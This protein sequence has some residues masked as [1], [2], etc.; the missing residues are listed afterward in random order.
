MNILLIN[1]EYPPIGGG[2]GNATMF[3][4][5]ALVQL[6]HRATVLTSAF[7]E[8]ANVREEAGVAIHRLKVRRLEAN[9]AT[10][11]E[12]LS[13]VR[14]ALHAAPAVAA[15]SGTQ[16]VIVFFTLPCG[17]VAL[18]LHRRLGLPYV[19]SLRGGDVPGLVPEIRW[20]HAVLKPLRR[21]VLR[22][23]RAIVANDAGLAGLSSRAD[24]FPVRI[25]PNGVDSDFYRPP[26]SPKIKTGPTEILFVGRLHRQKN[27][28]FFLEQLA[29]LHAAEPGG[30][31]LS[32]VGDGEERPAL[33]QGVKRL[34]L[35]GITSWLGWQ[36]DKS[37]LLE[38]YQRADVVVNPS[39]YEG[40]PNVVLEAMACG[41][42]VVA[43]DVPGNN[44]LVRP[45]QTGFLFTLN[46]GPGLM[47]ALR[48]LRADP[49]LARTLGEN[50]RQRVQTEFSWRKVAQCYLELFQPDHD[51]KTAAL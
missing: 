46:D 35:G 49:V 24:P 45:G 41:L 18:S 9:R 11:R 50:A 22:S 40:M 19:V 28:P 16:A 25:I 42:P 20:Q 26:S 3:L 27:L 14:A 17:P 7:Q 39:H 48:A 31:R 38:I 6:G 23:A 47:A 34:G 33:E 1:Y 44:T 37:R 2:A 36:K 5:R 29:R 51:L 21:R 43:S 10:A 8:E 13:F 4:S 32:V 30:W 12:M 15:R